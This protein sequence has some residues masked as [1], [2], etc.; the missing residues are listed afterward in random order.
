MA[1]SASFYFADFFV[2]IADFVD[3]IESGDCVDFADWVYFAELVEF[4]DP[5]EFAEFADA[6]NYVA[7]CGFPGSLQSGDT[8]TGFHNLS[9]SRRC[10]LL[11]PLRIPTLFLPDFRRVT[12]ARRNHISPAQMPNL[13]TAPHRGALH[14][15]SRLEF[16]D[17]TV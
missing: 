6:G 9:K 16:R 12:F 2:D 8:S 13:P 10:F 7:F 17:A 15:N 3:F 5:V 1:N 11:P 4:D 14:F